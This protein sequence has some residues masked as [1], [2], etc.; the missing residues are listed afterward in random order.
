VTLHATVTQK[1]GYLII[2]TSMK[3]SKYSLSIPMTHT[4]YAR[5]L[6]NFM[7]DADHLVLTA[8][9]GTWPKFYF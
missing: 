9:Y 6:H 5:T 4:T 3:Y 1:M 2:N 7:N 8:D